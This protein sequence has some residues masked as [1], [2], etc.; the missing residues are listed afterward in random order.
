MVSFQRSL[1]DGFRSTIKKEVVTMKETGKSGTKNKTVEVYN[2]KIIFSRVMY[3]LSAG[4][5]QMED[6]FKYELAPVPTALFKD[7]GEGRYPT[8]KA[9]L[10]NAL[11]VGVSTRTT[12][13]DAIII[14]GCAML[15][16][17]I[18][19]PKGG[20]VND[21]LAGVRS[22]I[23]NK[24]K[25]SDVYLIFDRYKEFS[26]KTATRQKRLDQF[27]CSHTL[28]KTS[29]LPSKEVTL[30]VTKTKAHLIEM[31]KADL[32]ENLP[33]FSNK[34]IITSK[35]DITEQLYF[36]RQSEPHDLI[37]GFGSNH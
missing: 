10:K 31:V 26:I 13:P 3:L 17:A 18:H 34:F 35:Q 5:I 21:F 25:K 15:Y 12:V 4:H 14:D 29:P 1:P 30:R 8:S 19:W 36:S 37:T 9:V 33:V 7:T 6:L 11:K 20:K 28:N 16:S 23:S 24:L 22:Y 2:T 27:R 32:I